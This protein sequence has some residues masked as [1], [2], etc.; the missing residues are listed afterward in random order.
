MED[1][2]GKI[3]TGSKIVSSFARVV[4]TFLLLSYLGEVPLWAIGWK[5]FPFGGRRAVPC[6]AIP[7]LGGT[8]SGSSEG[9][10]AS[11]EGESGSLDDDEQM[12]QWIR[13]LRDRSSP[14]KRDVLVQVFP[15]FGDEVID[16]LLVLLSD[17]LVLENSSSIGLQKIDGIFNLVMQHSSELIPATLISYRLQLFANGKADLYFAYHED[18]RDTEASVSWRQVMNDIKKVFGIHLRHIDEGTIVQTQDNEDEGAIYRRIN[19]VRKNVFAS[20]FVQLINRGRTGLHEEE[21]LK[22]LQG[23]KFSCRGEA[24]SFL[25]RA[26]CSSSYV[27][28]RITQTFQSYSTSCSRLA[29]SPVP[30]ETNSIRRLL[31]RCHS[32]KEAALKG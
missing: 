17:Y 26:Q 13:Q 29:A 5:L 8:E 30:W 27:N 9:E 20:S 12:W 16:D 4:F 10:S 21:F 28:F 14:K 7:G 1:S 23:N 18:L 24:G 11:S 15:T 6:A 25:K 31:S 2:I 19:G 3:R 22:A 32:K